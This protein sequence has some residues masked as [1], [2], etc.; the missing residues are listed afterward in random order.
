MASKQNPMVVTD[1]HC[2][3]D[4]NT[5]KARRKELNVGNVWI[6]GIVCHQCADFIRSKNR[7]DYVSCKCGNVSVDGGS[8]YGKA[9]FRDGRNSFTSISV[10]YNDVESTDSTEK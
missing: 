4:I 3:T 8:W 9:S 5:P 6:N 10:P 2:F 7:H 1:Y